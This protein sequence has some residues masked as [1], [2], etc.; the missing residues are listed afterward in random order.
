MSTSEKLAVIALG[1]RNSGKSK[2]WNTFFG[3]TVR[4]GKHPKRLFFTANQ[5]VNV[6]L[7]SGSPEERKKF[8][9]D[10]IKLELNI[11]IVLCSMQYH[12][13]CTN[14]INFFINNNFKFYVHWLNPGFCDKNVY[15]DNLG[16][17]PLM[18][19]HGTVLE[20]DGRLTPSERVSE[21]R[22]YIF[23]WATEKGIFHQIEKQRV[24]II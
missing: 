8:I 24:K 7:I 5:Y 21:M 12:I 10:F 16:I 15:Q 9:G 3:R 18:R 20:R 22:Q 14:T 23:N 2:T 17:I 4:T 13:N 6:L 1:H 11:Q 19:K